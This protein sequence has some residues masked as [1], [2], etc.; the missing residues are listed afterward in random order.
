MVE[1]SSVLRTW[2]GPA[3][4]VAGLGQVTPGM[5]VRVPLG[6]L[7]DLTRQKLIEEPTPDPTPRRPPQVLDKGGE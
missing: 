6:R 4:Q 3:G 5:I 1:R 2:R 7:P